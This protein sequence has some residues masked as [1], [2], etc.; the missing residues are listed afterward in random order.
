MSPTSKRNGD[1]PAGAQPAAGSSDDAPGGRDRSSLTSTYDDHSVA[2]VVPAY[3][4][5][6]HVGEV[7]DTIPAFVDRIYAVDD[8]STDDTW[9]EIRRR[10][11]EASDA[12]RRQLSRA[13]GGVAVERPDPATNGD[14]PAD[15]V[16]VDDRIVPIRHEE[17][18][19]AGA[20]IRTGYRHA[21]R[22]GM[23]VT[24]AMD[25]DGQMDPD[26]MPDLVDP[27]VEGEA[28]YAKGN[29]LADP[30]VREEM[31]GFRLFGNW[32]LTMLTKIASGYWETMDPQN[33]YTAI[34]HEALDAIDLDAIPDGHDYTNDLLVRLSVAE[35][36]VADVSMPAR[37]GDEA[38]T[39]DYASFAPKTSWTLLQSFFWRLR[40]TYLTTDF[41]PLVFLY[42][43]GAAGAGA[44]AGL[45][46][47]ALR[48]DDGSAVP[49]VGAVLS[50]LLGCL[51]VVAAMVLDAETDA[52]EEV[53]R[54]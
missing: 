23:D 26:R 12:D 2:V 13:D 44:A 7:L 48:R 3:N 27:I 28:G 19:G 39:I 30:E 29:R 45:V 51:A 53:R 21:H 14:A 32:L 4:E 8:R 16:T 5:D 10:V 22:D 49:T 37:Y 9:A 47:D 18:Q 24:V 40:R 15:D 33:G 1:H 46:A 52:P 31:P 20:G 42:G 41:H 35:V 38:S 50:F 11:P 6:D 43:L 36:A 54:E 25:G 17:N 34:S